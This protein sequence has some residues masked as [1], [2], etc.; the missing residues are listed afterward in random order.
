MSKEA[1]SYFGFKTIE[2]Q[3]K[4]ERKKEKIAKIA[5]RLNK[6]LDKGFKGKK[7]KVDV[8]AGYQALWKTI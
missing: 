3:E 8:K 1:K 7:P 6:P 5:K 4:L 2:E